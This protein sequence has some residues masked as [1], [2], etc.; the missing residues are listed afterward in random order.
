MR[1]PVPP[2]WR[3]AAAA[4]ALRLAQPATFCLV[5]ELARPTSSSVSLIFSHTR[6][7]PRKTVGRAATSEFLSVPLSASG[8]ANQVV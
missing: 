2:S 1:S 3:V 6:G 7:T 4:D 5:F 8:R